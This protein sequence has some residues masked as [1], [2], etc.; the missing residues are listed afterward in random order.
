MVFSVEAA[1]LPSIDFTADWQEVVH[2]KLG[3][4]RDFQINYAK[5]RLE[6]PV[7][8][9]YKFNDGPDFESEPLGNPDDND[10]SHATISIPIDADKV[11]IWFKHENDPD[12][13]DSDFGNNYHFSIDQPSIVFLDDWQEKQHGELVP[14]GT[15]DLFYDSKRLKEGVQ[16]QAQM[17]FVDDQVITKALQISDED[18]PYQSAVISIPDDAE[19]VVLWFYYTDENGNKQ[20]DSDFGANYEFP[21]A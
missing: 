18:S 9:Q 12:T 13:W 10:L 19:K 6:A 4:G 5:S 14:G 1:P 8:V 21:L 7:L 16:V 11:V 17:K 3:V 15:F 20:Y 2:G